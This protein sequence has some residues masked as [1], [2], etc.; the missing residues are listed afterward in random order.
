MTTEG[1]LQ[2]GGDAAR[3]PVSRVWIECTRSYFRGGN[4]GIQ[5][6]V[7]NVV[8]E[9][10]AAGLRRGVTCE[11]LVWAGF[12]AVR[13]RRALRVQ[14]HWVSELRDLGLAVIGR[15]VSTLGR[16]V[17]VWIRNL[18]LAGGRGRLA[19]LQ[20]WCGA[21]LRPILHRSAGIAAF[22]LEF[23]RGRSIDLGP[24]DL[25]L[26][27]DSSWGIAGVERL[28]RRA[29]ARGARIGLVVHD[30]IPID[31]PELCSFATR[32][33]ATWLEMGLESAD[34][35]VSVSD[36]T[37]V[38]LLQHMAEKGG[39]SP[40]VPTGVFRLGAELDLAAGQAATRP[41]VAKALAGDAPL[42]LTVGTLEP[43]KNHALVLE[44]FE[45]LW[46]GGND[47]RLVIAGRAGWGSEALRERLRLHP[48]KGRRLFVFEDLS[49]DELALA[50]E[51]ARAVVCASF[52][53]GFGLPVVEALARR[54]PV[55]ASDIPS[56]MEVGGKHGIYF[57]RHSAEALRAAIEGF[58]ANGLPIDVQPPETFV[59]PDWWES[60]IE[61]LDQALRL[62]VARPGPR[63]PAR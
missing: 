18:R 25:L 12:G 30:L 47:L 60:T 51:R 63:P 33:F 54:V 58:E 19:R 35:V 17:P 49:D 61:L 56:H 6:V 29:R 22:P 59:W 32:S 45:A 39:G 7:R 20:A 44:A 38:R 50:Y 10:S 23:L 3:E 21:Q 11:P 40:A 4:T 53:E 26:L 15:A 24:G 5:R 41:G 14:P 34:F 52:A 2:A 43:R 62:A 55:F 48:E 28:V 9:S 37:R 13:P 46:A 1:S 42:Y 8:R 36:A 31:Q 57:P 16:W 27:L